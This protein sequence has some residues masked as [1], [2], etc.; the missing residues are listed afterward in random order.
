MHTHTNKVNMGE[1]II[2]M[3]SLIYIVQ[4]Y[5]LEHRNTGDLTVYKKLDNGNYSVKQKEVLYLDLQTS[6]RPLLLFPNR[7]Y[8]YLYLSSFSD[9]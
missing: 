5:H 1:A 4:T 6:Q 3:G 7:H 8:S 9:Y 2:I